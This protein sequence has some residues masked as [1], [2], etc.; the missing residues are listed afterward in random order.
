LKSQVEEVDIKNLTKSSHTLDTFS[1][2]VMCQ[3]SPH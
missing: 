1:Q 3:V 2:E